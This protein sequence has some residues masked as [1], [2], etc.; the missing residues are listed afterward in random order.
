MNESIFGCYLYFNQTA[1]FW[2]LLDNNKT[3]VI[4]NS[5]NWINYTVPDRNIL[6]NIMCNTSLSGSKVWAA[7]NYTVKVDTVMPI[8]T[9]VNPSN[10]Q[11]IKDNLSINSICTDPYVYILNYTFYNSSTILN[12]TQNLTTSGST[13]TLNLSY[14]ISKYTNGIYYLN[15]SCSD[16]HTAKL[17]N[18][19]TEIK[20][21]KDAIDYNFNGDD[22][23]V[24]VISK[25]A[26]ITNINTTK[27]IDRYTLDVSFDKPVDNFQYKISG[28]KFVKYDSKYKGHI[29]IDDKY[30]FDSEPY[31]SDISEYGDGYIVMDVY[32]PTEKAQLTTESI[33]GLNINTTTLQLEFGYYKYIQYSPSVLEN[34]I[35]TLSIDVGNRSGLSM[36]VDIRYNNTF[37]SANYTTYNASDGYTTYFFNMVAPSV[38]QDSQVQFYFNYTYSD[39]ITG[40]TE[41]NNQ[42][43]SN[44]G[45]AECVGTNISALVLTFYD[46]SGLY[47]INVSAQA[48]IEL[49]GLSSTNTTFSPINFTNRYNV[50]LCLNPSNTTLS[51]N[52]YILDTANAGYTHRYYMINQTISNA[53]TYLKLYNY[54]STTGI[55]TLNG[56]LRDF[57]TGQI[58][59]NI[60]ASLY[61][62]YPS[63]NT[64]RLVQ[65]GE[66]DAFGQVYFNVIEDTTD[67][68]I[69]YS[70]ANN[71]N[72]GQTGKM[73]MSCSAGICSLT[74]QI[75][76]SVPSGSTFSYTYNFD[77]STNM[78]TMDF[79][80]SNG[81]SHTVTLQASKGNTILCTNSTVGVMGTLSCNIGTITGTIKVTA[82]KQSDITDFFYTYIERPQGQLWQ[83][84][85]KYRGDLVFYSTGIFITAT[86][87]GLPLGPGG[88]ILGAILGL[89]AIFF[90]KTIYIPIIIFV[91]ALIFLIII[92]AR[93]DHQ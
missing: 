41:T 6:W 77:N 88:A 60:Y 79:S 72:L 31:D 47:L 46:E 50:S 74:L 49:I 12:S 17:F 76:P 81:N 1:V 35:N 62:Y 51:V 30:W 20:Q 57:I 92:G 54:N 66:S 33:G 9:I 18:P 8:L 10:M 71:N 67:Y 55:S 53:T 15:I 82:R 59:P 78:I 68:N 80:E 40:V 84:A 91:S 29:I 86:A 21:E 28:S 4:N 64:W 58:T 83:I 42:T 7:N 11:Y 5:L 13:L 63:E 56:V 25:G 48:N 43:V 16:G 65:M 38:S 14:N 24:Q 32:M 37:Y 19:L 27:L 93:G 45:I 39:G 36:D 85:G 2:N 75:N 22:I 26:A 61:R 3:P 90:L 23:N 73:I 69:M 87:A 44:L 70:D 34:Q 52:A 89:V